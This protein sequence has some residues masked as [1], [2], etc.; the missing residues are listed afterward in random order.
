MAVERRGPTVDKR[1]V[2][3][4]EDR[5]SRKDSTTEKGAGKPEE[6]PEWGRRRKCPRKVSELRQKLYQKAK[7][8][9]K[10]RFY[11][12]YDRIYRTDVLEAAWQ[13]VRRNGGAAGVDG[14]TV[15]QIE[16]SEGGPQGMVQALQEELRTK[17]YRPQAV[18]RV[19][20]PKAHGGERPL[21]IPTVRD[22]V[23]QMAA[24]LILEAI[25]E[26]DFLGCS[27]GFR[28]RKSAHQALAAVRDELRSGRQMVYDADLQSYFDRIPHDRL[29]AAVAKRIADRSV[30]RLIRLWLRAPVEDTRAGGG[31]RRQDTG[32]PQGGVISPLLANVYLHWF[33][34]RFHSRR[35]PAQW[36]DAR[37]VRY[38]DDLVILARRVGPELVSWVEATLEQWMGLELN[39]EKTRLVDVQEAG[40][41]L[42]FLGYTYRYDLDLKGRGHR[43][44]NIL[45]SKKSLARERG[46]L[47]EL[48]SPRLCFQP[49]P[50]M[51]Q[52]LNR[53]LQGWSN[54]YGF[55]YPRRSFRH[56]NTYVRQRLTKHLRRRSQRPW[57]PPAGVSTY[58]HLSDLGLVYL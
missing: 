11:A 36:A 37:L 49:L 10:F 31:P 20:I 53:H 48:T 9:P 50:A 58:R 47:R 8:E 54:Y 21:G 51:I 42:D 13:Q 26:A 15:D 29:M 19:Y 34:H 14:V 6:V 38:A 57:Q 25:F 23:V 1:T 46:K 5:L 17:S 30:L 45:P 43:Y 55:G 2:R 22:R 16:N 18:R 27:Y 28:P 33:D 41:A 7:R 32:T 12:L 40:A 4:E 56:I 39:R 44:L 3:S 24:L 35:G 52:Q